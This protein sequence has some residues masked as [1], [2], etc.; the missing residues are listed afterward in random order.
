VQVVIRNVAASGTRLSPDYFMCTQR[1][2][3]ILAKVSDKPGQLIEW[4]REVDK[5][6]QTPT[7]GVYYLNVD[8]FNEQTNDI[9][10]TGQQFKWTEGKI[11]NAIGSQVYFRPGIDVTMVSM[12]DQS[13]GTPVQ[14]TGFNQTSGAFAYLLTPVNNLACGYTSGT[15]AAAWNSNTLY[16]VGAVVTLGSAVWIATNSTTNINQTPVANSNHW[17]PYA[18]FN[19]SAG[20]NL[21]PGVDFWYEQIRQTNICLKT[22]GG[23]ELIGIPPNIAFTVTDQDGYV[24]RRGTDYTMYGNDFIQLASFS[25]AGSTL[26]C[27]AVMKVDPTTT[28]GTN[29]ENILQVG[30]QDNET[31]A[32]GQVFLHTTAGNFPSTPA[33]ID[34]TITIPQLLQPGEWCRWEARIE[35]PQV[36]ARGKKWELNSFVIVDPHSIEFKQPPTEQGQSPPAPVQ[37]SAGTPLLVD[38]QPQYFLPGLHVAIGDQVIVGDQ[39]AVIVSPSITETYEV[40]GSK[41]NLN[42][43]LE[44]KSND[45]QTSSDLAE[46]LK[47][48]LLIMGRENAEADGLTVFEATRDF[49]GTQRDPSATAPSY[50]YTVSISASADWKVFVPLIT[51]MVKF[52]I[53][54]TIGNS[55]FQGKLQ[56][57]NRLTALGAS[58]FIPSYS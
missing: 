13:S 9:G 10:V 16:A 12:T 8:Y 1:G 17:A 21:V 26:Y 29:P 7:A 5:T 20:Q 32:S 42:F 3:A 34:G 6:R 37:V 2:R 15:D 11:T 58:Q 23:V 41:E 35:V 57:A 39:A 52:E 44:V 55:D 33:N 43:T 18:A 25:P 49:Q 36:K 14:F 46:M 4:V 19:P 47:Q 31:L 27:N 40:F 48:Q 45:L 38:G 22:L 51:R 56:M 28:S 50:I 30:L 53:I 24:L 54:D